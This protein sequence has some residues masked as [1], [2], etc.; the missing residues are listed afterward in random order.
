MIYGNVDVTV[1]P[2]G[3][4][5]I[6]ADTETREDLRQMLNR[7]GEIVA[8][9]EALEPY[10]TNGGYQPFDAGEG[11]P[12]VGLTCAP[13][14]AE[15]LDTH[16]DGKHEI[17]GRFWYYPDYMLRSPVEQLARTGRVVFTEA[18]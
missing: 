13:C 17:V 15:C 6:T 4:L 11:N 9:M 5:E 8:L 2:D 12:F 10:W 3:N 1:L 16:D 18:R 7:D 14:I